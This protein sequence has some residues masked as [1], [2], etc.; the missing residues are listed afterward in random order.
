MHRLL[1][2]FRNLKK[3]IEFLPIVWKHQDWDYGYIFTFNYE[4]HK[5]LYKALYIDGVHLPNKNHKRALQT[6]QELY[7]RLSKEEYSNL[8]DEELTRLYGDE[9]YYFKPVLGSENKT[10]GPYTTLE[11]TRED[12]LTLDQRKQYHKKMRDLYKHAEYL[13]KQDKELLSKLLIKYS[14]HFWD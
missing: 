11:S 2:F 8:V 14:D 12:R 9:E 5:R 10:W 4:L 7:N 13:K 1:N 6:I 3:V